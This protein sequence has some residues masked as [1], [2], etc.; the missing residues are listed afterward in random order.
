MQKLFSYL[1]LVHIVLKVDISVYCMC[2]DD[3]GDGHPKEEE[4]MTVPEYQEG[5]KISVDSCMYVAAT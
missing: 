2:A 1:L 3:T 4:E 5:R